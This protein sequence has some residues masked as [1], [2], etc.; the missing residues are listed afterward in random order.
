VPLTLALPP[1]VNDNDELSLDLGKKKK[2]KK[3]LV[4]GDDLGVRRRESRPMSQAAGAPCSPA[5]R[6]CPLAQPA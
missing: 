3:A 1:A 5:L 2:K 6:P 4:L